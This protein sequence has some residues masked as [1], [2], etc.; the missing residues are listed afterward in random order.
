MTTPAPGAVT[1]VRTSVMPVI[2]SG[3]ANDQFRIRRPAQPVGRELGERL[4]Q[5]ALVRVPAVAEAQ[6]GDDGVL[7]L[8][9]DVEVHLGDERGQDVGRILPPLEALA[10]PKLVQ[11]AV[12]KDWVHSA[13]VRP[14]TCRSSPTVPTIW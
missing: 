2:T 9:R 5:L 4:A 10:L 1:A 12:A 13:I 14:V 11:R 8:R 6:S 7:D 3:I